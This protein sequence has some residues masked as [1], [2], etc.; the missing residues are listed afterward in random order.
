MNIAGSNRWLASVVS[1]ALVALLVVGEKVAAQQVRHAITPKAARRASDQAAEKWLQKGI[2]GFSVAILQDGKLVLEKSYGKASVELD[3]PMPTKAVYEI[4]SDA[5]PF[6][7]AAVLRLA[8]EGK[9]RL[10]DP[11]AK[12]L[13]DVLAPGLAQRVTLRQMLT[14][15]AGIP[16]YTVVAGFDALS[17]QNVPAEAVLELVKNEPALFEPGSAQAYS[18]TGYLLLGLVVKKVAGISWADYVEK[19]FFKPLGMADSRASMNQEIVPG[20]AMPYE[21]DGE[22]LVRAPHHAYELIHGNGGLRSTARDMATWVNALH[23]GRVL[24]PTLY[25][26]MMTPGRLATGTTL[27][28]GL[29]IVV[30]GESLGHRSFSHGGTFPGYMSHAAY[31]PDQR[32][33]I[34]VLTN[35]TGPYAEDSIARDILT[36]LIGDKRVAPRPYPL[37][38]DQYVGEYVAR[39]RSQRVMKVTLKDGGLQAIVEPW[40]RGPRDF[41]AVGPD[42]F[43]SEWFDL[44]FVR[45]DGRIV[46]VVR[47]SQVSTVPFDRR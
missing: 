10:D 36:P 14:H 15:T 23:T 9:L 7:A 8:G 44:E 45:K 24:A 29:G 31:L 19:E 30:S 47:S 11:L 43:T 41:V 12:Y 42:R 37:S 16:E 21:R 35:T 32:L 22:A 40:D 17:T 2:A 5:K 33:A 25:R 28:Y 27:R 26:E 18:N 4:A 38:L 20:L 34:A 6:T 39:V 46:G 13:P 3:A 1:T